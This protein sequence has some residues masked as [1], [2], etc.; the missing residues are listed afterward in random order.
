MWK[1]YRISIK[2]KKWRHIDAHKFR[3]KIP[4]KTLTFCKTHLKWIIFKIVSIKSG[5]DD[6][7]WLTNRKWFE[8][9]LQQFI[10]K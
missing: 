3:S 2:T 1:S 4:N 10:E 5:G 8:A 7:I 6:Q 9:T